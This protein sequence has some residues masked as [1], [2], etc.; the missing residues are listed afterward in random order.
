MP[1]GYAGDW[2]RTQYPDGSFGC[3]RP[4]RW[5]PTSSSQVLPCESLTELARGSSAYGRPVQRVAEDGLA[6]AAGQAG[7][8]ESVSHAGDC[9][10]PGMR[11][12]RGQ[13]LAVRQWA[14]R[15]CGAV[16]DERGRGD[17]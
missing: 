8:E 3:R 9:L 17:L 7:G 4:L 16:D 10:Q 15:V 6:D 13:G 14:Q 5:Q 11:D 12:L 2:A 1:P